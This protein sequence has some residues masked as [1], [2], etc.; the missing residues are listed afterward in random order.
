[1]NI[2]DRLDQAQNLKIL[3]DALECAR[4]NEFIATQ[5]GK[6]IFM[7]ALKELGFKKVYIKSEPKKEENK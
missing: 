2:I 1:M 7:D 4:A 3:A 5:E 6:N